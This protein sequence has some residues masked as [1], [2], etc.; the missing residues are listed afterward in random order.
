M[1]QAGCQADC[2]SAAG[3]QR[4]R[5]AA[6]AWAGAGNRLRARRGSCCLQAGSMAVQESGRAHRPCL[7]GFV[8]FRVRGKPIHLDVV[9]LEYCVQKFLPVVLVRS[10]RWQL[11]A[12]RTQR[13]A[14]GCWQNPSAPVHEAR[15]RAWGE[16]LVL[17]W[18]R[19]TTNSSLSCMPSCRPSCALRTC[20]RTCAPCSTRPGR[21]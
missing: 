16:R 3:H 20:W 6:S 2:T 7:Q 8:Q 18:C 1:P 15:R 11:C 14:A 12:G 5:R 17:Q 4:R 9:S 10:C 21:E 13:T 19:M